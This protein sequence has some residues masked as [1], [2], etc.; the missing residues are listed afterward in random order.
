MAG[1]CEAGVAAVPLVSDPVSPSALSAASAP[2]DFTLSEV[3]K[4]GLPRFF[5]ITKTFSP[6]FNPPDALDDELLE[7]LEDVEPPDELH[8]ASVA[9]ATRRTAGA[10]RALL[11]EPLIPESFQLGPKRHW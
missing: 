7:E 8:A 4:Y 3:V 2:P 6:V 10:H 1:S 9:D 5:G 11:M